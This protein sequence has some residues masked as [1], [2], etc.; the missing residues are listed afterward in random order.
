MLEHQGHGP[1]LQPSVILANRMEQG[2]WNMET[3]NVSLLDLFS[4]RS[5]EARRFF[6]VL[7]ASRLL[8]AISIEAIL[9][10][11]HPSAPLRET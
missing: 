2:R 3:I 9:S 10:K 7:L 5:A 6:S 11:K 1:L 4:R 8:A